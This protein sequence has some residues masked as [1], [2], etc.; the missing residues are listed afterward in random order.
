MTCERGTLTSAMV[1]TCTPPFE[2]AASSRFFFFAWRALRYPPLACAGLG[3]GAPLA[4]PPSAP[5]AASFIACSF[6]RKESE[7]AMSLKGIPTIWTN[8]TR[9]GGIYPRYGPIRQEEGEYTCSFP[10]K[11]SGASAAASFAFFLRGSTKSC[12]SQGTREHIPGVGTNRDVPQRGG[13]G[14]GEAAHDHGRPRPRA[15]SPAS[16]TTLMQTRATLVQTR[17]LLIQI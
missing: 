3:E 13:G 2:A 5:S 8:P 15:D 16:S 11:E 12:Q 9:G 7:V 17:A 10:R 6:P 1:D 4:A 14:G